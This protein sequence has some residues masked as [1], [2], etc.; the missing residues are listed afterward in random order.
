[1]PSK[2]KQEYSLLTF[3]N[4][5]YGATLL[6]HAAVDTFRHIDVIPG[7]T[8]TPV[9]ALLGLNCDSPGRADGFAELTGYTAFFACG[10]AAQSMF[11]AKTRGD[12]TFFERVVDCVAELTELVRTIFKDHV[13][14]RV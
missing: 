12:G 3:H 8:P 14:A 13:F 5:I 4:S 10:I 6:A 2:Q 7:C 1:M 11:A 9:L